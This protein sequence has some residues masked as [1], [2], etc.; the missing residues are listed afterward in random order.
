MAGCANGPD[1]EAPRSCMRRMTFWLCLHWASLGHELH[2]SGVHGTCTYIS[3]ALS[4]A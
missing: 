2:V 1:N 3:M 4:A